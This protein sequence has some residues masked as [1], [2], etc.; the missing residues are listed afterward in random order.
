MYTPMHIHLYR[1][2]ASRDWCMQGFQHQ[3]T[4][5]K[6]TFSDLLEALCIDGCSQHEGNFSGLEPLAYNVAILHSTLLMEE[7]TQGSKPR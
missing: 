3:A 2:R 6:I 7:I 1:A 5:K 4:S